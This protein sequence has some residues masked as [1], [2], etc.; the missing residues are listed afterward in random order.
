MENEG[1]RA[2]FWRGAFLGLVVGSVLTMLTTPRTGEEM[3]TAIREKAGKTK[4]KIGGW[5]RCSEEETAQGDVQ[6]E[7]AGQEETGQEEARQADTEQEDAG[8]KE[9]VLEEVIQEE[10]SLITGTEE[11]QQESDTM[12]QHINEPVADRLT[13]TQKVSKKKRNKK[14]RDISKN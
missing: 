13:G 12:N 1:S 6:E 10:A 9:A 7:D 5:R 4:E 11:K 3:R 14:K 2:T 8:Q